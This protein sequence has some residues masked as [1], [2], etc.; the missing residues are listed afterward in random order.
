MKGQE[1]HQKEEE[2]CW[3]GH[4]DPTEGRVLGEGG[5]CRVL[6]EVVELE[7]DKQGVY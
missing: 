5:W 7:G 1:V 3:Q 2:G 4:G 6:V